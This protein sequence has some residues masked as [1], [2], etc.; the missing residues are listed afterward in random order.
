MAVKKG[1]PSQIPD[2]ALHRAHR[3]IVLHSV[4]RGQSVAKAWPRKRGPKGT[5]AQLA[6]REAFGRLA[7]AFN[8]IADSEKLGARLMA[9]GTGYTWR[10]VLMRTMTGRFFLIDGVNSVDAQ[11]T[12][13]AISRQIGALLVRTDAGWLGLSPGAEGEVLTAHGAGALPSYDVVVGASTGLFAALLSDL[14]TQASTALTT[15]VN[16]S[17]TT[18]ADNNLGITLDQATANAAADVLH[19]ISRTVPATPYTI[20]VLALGELRANFSAWG[21]GW[22]D[23]TK[24]D[25]LYMGYDRFEHVTW[26][27]ATHAALVTNFSQVLPPLCW[28]RF[29]DDGTNITMQTSFSG[30]VWRTLYTHAKSTAYLGSSG[31]S[32]FGIYTDGFNTLSGVTIVSFAVT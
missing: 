7:S 32:D 20:T 25:T 1:G 6:A 17:P 24:W 16:L 8:D 4:W 19:G 23:G 14:P 27:D 2:A 21:L 18:V 5:P 9:E 28:F 26:S 31:H 12:L 13:D 29:T 11:E 22:S 30:V 15:S 3:G 10:D